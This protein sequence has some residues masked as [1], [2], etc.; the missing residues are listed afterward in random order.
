MW[1]TQISARILTM[2]CPQVL[3]KLA[4]VLH[5][6]N[7]QDHVFVWFG[8]HIVCMCSSVHHFQILFEVH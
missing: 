8:E 7:I 2:R 6:R 3:D 4:V 1:P 5:I